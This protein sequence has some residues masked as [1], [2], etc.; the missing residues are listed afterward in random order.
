MNT[1]AT[2]IAE[3]EPLAAESLAQWVRESPQLAL[4]DTCADGETALARILEL[5]PALVLMDISMPGMTGLQ[6]VRR[7]RDEGVETAVIFTT[8]YD[9]HALVAFELHAVDYLLKPFSR[10]RF[11]EAVAHALSRQGA[12]AP[13]DALEA[14]E[15][16]EPLTRIF[17]RDRN[18]IVPLAVDRIEYFQSDHK[19]TSVAS[20]GKTYLVRVPITGFEHRLDAQRFLKLHRGCIVNLEF[21]E[22]M[23]PL[24]TSQL[25][26][27]MRSGAQFT[28]TREV[29][30]KLREQSL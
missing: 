7:L 21:V 10:E 13:L 18:A 24:E 30:R 8:A 12:G 3:D 4:V 6:V 23:T 17:V 26:V 5:R 28:A 29:S 11:D 1:I 2:L 16:A 14:K 25:A 27:R 20:G 22:S 15:P 9:E 19:Y